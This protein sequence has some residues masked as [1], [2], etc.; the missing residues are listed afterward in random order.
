[1]RISLLPETASRESQI[2]NR[3]S[4]REASVSDTVPVRITVNGGKITITVKNREQPVL[5]WE[6]DW[7]KASG[8][9]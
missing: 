5:L 3:E 8:S 4:E 7:Q 2:V 1:M 6:V 9:F